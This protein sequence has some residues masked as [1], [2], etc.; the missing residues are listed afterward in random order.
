MV[1]G[2][3]HEIHGAHKA[4]FQF[5][6]LSESWIL[7]VCTSETKFPFSIPVGCR[8]LGG[9]RGQRGKRRRK[10]RRRGKGQE[11]GRRGEVI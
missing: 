6:A 7:S 9:L 8:G 1:V 11:E 10:K 2:R 3:D 4:L 5:R